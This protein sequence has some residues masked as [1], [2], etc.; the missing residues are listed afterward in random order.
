MKSSEDSPTPPA[1]RFAPGS[2][3]SSDLSISSTG[4]K[5]PLTGKRCADSDG[6]YSVERFRRYDLALGLYSAISKGR[7]AGDVSFPDSNCRRKVYRLVFDLLYHRGVI[8]EL[9]IE[10]GFY[11]RNCE[12]HGQQTL[13]QLMTYD[14]QQWKFSLK[15]PREDLENVPTLMLTVAKA[16][17]KHRV[18]LNAALARMRVKSNAQTTSHLMTEA[19]FAKYQAVVTQPFHVRINASKVHNLQIG[20][21]SPLCED[22][23]TLCASREELKNGEKRFWQQERTLL[24]F[25]PDARE[26][27]LHHPLLSEG[28]LVIQVWKVW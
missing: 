17:C 19:C 18:R 9:L 23:Y 1:K 6:V 13:V 8:E 12:L 22:G 2:G 16:L 11:S 10:S 26:T 4:E 5:R 28:L 25:S 14:Y 24:A 20:V 15:L 7:F 21:I 3:G 27:F